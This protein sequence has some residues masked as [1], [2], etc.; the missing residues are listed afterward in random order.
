MSKSY[1][2]MRMVEE[3]ELDRLRTAQI[4]ERDPL[5][6]I[7]IRLRDEIQDLLSSS[8]MND[9]QKLAMIKQLQQSYARLQTQVDS[10][11]IPAPPIAPPAPLMAPP[12]PPDEEVEVGAAT[13]S[14]GRRRHRKRT[15]EARVLPAR[16]GVQRRHKVDPNN[17]KQTGEG[18]CPSSTQVRLPPPIPPRLHPP[19]GIP[20][21]RPPPGLLPHVL[22]V[23]R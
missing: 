13:T 14:K 19:L 9:A 18:Y 12:A 5:V 21:R 4:K 6:L 22:R 17:N 15:A 20:R 10:G 16:K 1:R 3:A 8:D 7:M 2:K 11:P 23:Y